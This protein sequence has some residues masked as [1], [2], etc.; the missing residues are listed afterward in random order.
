MSQCRV[1]IS[2]KHK[3]LLSHLY[4][5]A[6]NIPHSKMSANIIPRSIIHHVRKKE[7]CGSTRY[8][9]KFQK[10]NVFFLF[11]RG[12]NY[13]ISTRQT[14]VRNLFFSVWSQF[15]KFLLWLWCTASRSPYTRHTRQ[16]LTKFHY[17]LLL[18]QKSVSFDFFK[19]FCLYSFLMPFPY[20]QEIV[21]SICRRG[22]K[23]KVNVMD[24][25]RTFS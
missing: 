12:R 14:V 3:F 20:L 16:G 15:W 11:S 2:I 21:D 8:S 9:H 17:S 4:W 5:L 6:G 19:C 10:R 1:I 18:H 24:S 22:K 7:A 25:F 23:K 13:G